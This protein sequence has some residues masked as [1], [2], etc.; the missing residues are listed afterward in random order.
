MLFRLEVA[1]ETPGHV[2]A[3]R[4]VGEGHLVYTA[5]A[6]RTANTLIDMSTMVKVDEIREIM[7]PDPFDGLVG[8]PALTNRLKNLFLGVHLRVAGHTHLGRRHLGVGGTL[9]TKVTVA[10]V[11]TQTTYVMFMRK[12]NGLNYLVTLA[13]DKSGF[14]PDESRCEG[15]IGKEHKRYNSGLYLI[16]CIFMKYLRQGYSLAPSRDFWMFKAFSRFKTCDSSKSLR[17]FSQTQTTIC[18]QL[19]STFF[20]FV[21]WAE[22]KTFL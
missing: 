15:G 16:V 14:V 18:V 12:L 13:G 21:E 10:A 8:L 3:F 4:L 5:M 1:L 11:E 20:R 2:K 17:N 19:F 7:N 6:L 22:S 9:N